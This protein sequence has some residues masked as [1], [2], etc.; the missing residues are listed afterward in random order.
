MGLANIFLQ[1]TSASLSLNENYDSDVLKDAE[2]VLNRLVP[3]SANYRHDAEGPDDMP[4]HVKSALFGVSLNIPISDGKLA[5]GTWQGIWLCEHRNHGG[6]RNVV[7]CILACSRSDVCFL[8]V[9]VCQVTLQGLLKESSRSSAS[10][11]AS[12]SG[13]ARDSTDSKVDL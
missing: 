7:V 5:L 4:A 9:D 8:I 2:D 1:H 3:E 10:A 12:A 6:R 11:A 13:S